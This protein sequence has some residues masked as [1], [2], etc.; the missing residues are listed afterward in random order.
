MTRRPMNVIIASDFD[1]RLGDREYML[2]YNYIGSVSIEIT[3]TGFWAALIGTTVI[4][5]VLF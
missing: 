4:L 5:M 1:R 3:D 2:T